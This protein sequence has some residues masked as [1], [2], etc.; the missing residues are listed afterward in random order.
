VLL[1]VGACAHGGP[2]EANTAADAEAVDPC[3]CP[4]GPDGQLP[5]SP[6]VEQTIDALK[7]ADAGV[8]ECVREAGG[9]MVTIAVE[10]ASGAVSEVI[11]IDSPQPGSEAC[12]ERALRRIC[13]PRFQEQVFKVQFRYKVGP[14]WSRDPATAVAPRWR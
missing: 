3:S 9:V 11:G 4:Q 1:W 13:F 6:N 2:K 8:R 7:M 14:Q 10:G 12:V 5:V